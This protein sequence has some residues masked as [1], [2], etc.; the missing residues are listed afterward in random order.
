M[1][2]KIALDCPIIF[3]DEQKDINYVQLMRTGKF[4]EFEIT[5]ETFAKMKENFDNNVRKV[6]L[7]VDYFHQSYA[8]A[9]GWIKKVELSDDSQKLF[10]EVEW[11]PEAE[12]KIRDKEVR[13]LS[14]DFNFNYYDEE[15]KKS[16][17]PTLNGAGLTNRP[18]LKGMQAILSE[19]GDLT[20]FDQIKSAAMDLSDDEKAQLA[21]SLASALPK[22]FKM[23][24]L[25]QKKKEVEMS[26]S[27][28]DSAV[29]LAEVKQKY[30]EL[31]K[32]NKELMEAKEKQ[33]K[34]ASFEKLLSE[35]K[36]VEAQRQ[37][38]LEG[39]M[40]EFAKLAQPLNLDEKGHGEGG[41]EKDSE[42]VDIQGKV[43]ELAEAKRKEDTNLDYGT[44]LSLVLSENPDLNKKYEEV[45]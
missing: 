28:K 9:A 21:Q 20:E 4:D 35:G 27:D 6:E 18:F 12:K 11:T 33:E 37:S 14:A 22:D 29:E 44:A 43:H 41:K 19:E 15:T 25:T 34:T 3:D 10:I 2:H 13:Y 1:N 31:E 40:D 7:A 17:G 26:Q 30:A 42:D 38:Y 23:E 32:Q 24:N 36:A 39:K 8:E 16:Y 45:A 5:S